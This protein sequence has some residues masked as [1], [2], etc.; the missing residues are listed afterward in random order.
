MKVQ[1]AGLLLALVLAASVG[2]GTSSA[3]AS[4]VARIDLTGQGKGQVYYRLALDPPVGN[5]CTSSCEVEYSWAQLQALFGLKAIK[6][7]FVATADGGSRFVNWGGLCASAGT[8][9]S[10]SITVSAGTTVKVSARFEPAVE[11]KS[12][13]QPK[14]TT[15][16][17]PTAKS[18]PKPPTS[19]PT[20]LDPG[21]PPKWKL[22]VSE[23]VL[24]SV[25]GSYVSGHAEVRLAGV[26]LPA[27][28]KGKK[29]LDFQK[30]GRFWVLERHTPRNIRLLYRGQTLNATQSLQIDEAEP[31]IQYHFYF[32]PKG[33][34]R[35]VFL[36]LGR[37]TGTLVFITDAGSV[38][39]PVT[40]SIVP[41]GSR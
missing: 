29:H 37:G 30:G 1:W 41:Y 8:S 11:P 10:C 18:K 34:A 16:A 39:M 36:M 40:V 23:N 24:F 22:V 32:T 25:Q 12:P 31:A 17:A 28:K 9:R 5:P 38:R 7:T 13:A 14:T 3:A 35:P 27:L 33:A 15:S 26:Q 6:V 20:T 2:S 21:P 4:D 19:A